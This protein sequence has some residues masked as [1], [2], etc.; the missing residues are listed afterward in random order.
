MRNEIRNGNNA[1]LLHDLGT[2][3]L[4]ILIAYILV[5]TGTLADILNSVSGIFATF[6]AGAFFTSI[7]TTPPAMA[8]LGQIAL[9]QGTFITAL[10]GA[11]G[12]V[13]GDLIIFR[14][15]RDHFGEHVTE[16]LEHER[17]LR[18]AHVLFKRRSFR[19]LTFLAGGLILAS[20]LPDELGVA[21]LGFSKL[22]SKYFIV[23][24]YVFN[25]LGIFAIGLVAHSIAN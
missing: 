4:S 2:I 22:R 14:F 6:I 5:R 13:V 1:L 23:L 17:P 18:R 11:L 3:A 20:P 24:S 12:S 8:T 25:F 19:W 7:F 15:M 16:L 21:L 9:S 10:V